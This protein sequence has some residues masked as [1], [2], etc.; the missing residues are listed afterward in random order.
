MEI[1]FPNAFQMFKC[2][3]PWILKMLRLGMNFISILLQY[4][5]IPWPLR[6]RL[7][8][9][10]ASWYIF[11]KMAQ[12]YIPNNADVFLLFCFISFLFLEYLHGSGMTRHVWFIYVFGLPTTLSTLVLRNNLF[13]VENKLVVGNTNNCAKISWH[14]TNQR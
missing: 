12:H 2:N 9:I 10:R 14:I 13:F 7:L 3:W 1:S 5:D 11:D 4:P 8:W 6:E